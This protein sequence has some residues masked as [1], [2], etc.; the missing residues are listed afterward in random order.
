[1]QL[2]QYKELIGRE[3]QL[4]EDM[5]SFILNALKV[6]GNHITYISSNANDE[7]SSLDDKYPVISTL[8]GKHDTYNIAITDVYLREYESG[9]AE[10]YADGIDQDMETVKKD[11]LIHPEQFS[12]I[13]YFIMAPHNEQIFIFAS[14]LALKDLVDK[15]NKLPGEFF[16]ESGSIKNEFHSENWDNIQKYISELEEIYIRCSDPDSNKHN[17]NSD[18][19]AI[20]CELAE[21]AL[22]ENSRKLIEGLTEDESENSTRYTD[23]A[24]DE[25]ND[26]YDEIEGRVWELM[27]FKGI[28]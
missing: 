3:Q 5:K 15:Y 24:Q 21:L 7:D 6:K 28:D 16:K 27:N 2:K 12:D 14:R 1:M 19:M 18:L 8:W 13:V 22:I 4:K 26:L 20:I 11:F 17:I 9:Q 10:I 23:E 25:F